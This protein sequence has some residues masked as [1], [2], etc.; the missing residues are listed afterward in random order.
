MGRTRRDEILWAI[1]LLA[2]NLA[3]F[4]VFMVL[5]LG[6]GLA[7]AFF[8]W[9]VISAPEFVG[10]RNFARLLDDD[11]IVASAGITLVYFLEV[12]PSSVALGFL[13]ATV[14]D[15][16]WRGFRAFRVAYFMPII[17]SLVSSAVIWK[18]IYDSRYGVLNYLL[19]AV[20]LNPVAW[21]LD[22]GAV[23]HALALLS[24]WRILPIPILFFTAALQEVPR[25]L[26]EAARIDG[27]T[28]WQM[29]R[30]ITWPLVS[31]TTFFIGI[32]ATTF[33]LF[34]SFDLVSVM[35][36]GGP[37]DASD[38]LVYHV[39]V[40]AFERLLMG[41]AASLSTVL[42]LLILLITVLYFRAQARWVHY[43]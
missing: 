12:V 11:S 35:T 30:R 20:G 24:I 34:G 31:P 16:G 17:I 13:V 41:Y 37:S 25:D 6:A 2:P 9:D 43:G 15:A 19:G 36:R 4:V 7:L 8:K 26:Y 3:L 10:V 28:A 40:L 42:F 22:P 21:L 23:I 29:V 18:W 14:L 38:T 1:A 32:T 39:Y 5:P 33:A 27:A